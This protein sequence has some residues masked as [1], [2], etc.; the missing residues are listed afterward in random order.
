VTAL[1]PQSLHILVGDKVTSTED[2]ALGREIMTPPGDALCG[3]DI[4]LVFLDTPIDEVQP[5][6]VRATGA[7]RGDHLRTVG[8]SRLGGKRAADKLVRDHLPVL[9][10]AATELEIGEACDTHAGGPALDEA[11]AEIVGVASRAS[12]RCAGADARQVYTRTDAF[13]SFI[14]EAL[15]VHG[16]AGGAAAVASGS[17]KRNE[18]TRKG[19]VDV[20]ASCL[21]A[22]DCAAGICVTQGPREYCSRA[23]DAH[24]R[25][26]A[27]F[28]CKK[29]GGGGQAGQAGQAGQGGQASQGDHV[30][31]Q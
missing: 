15:A 20:G 6:S 4:A 26:P 5:L 25:C 3:A 1:A 24:D 14:G 27:H 2:R 12:S 18:R 29:A 23:C 16:G 19:P 22:D 8:F 9:D 11:T 21:R 31:A 13:A 7:A 10:V 30:C 28:R 17:P